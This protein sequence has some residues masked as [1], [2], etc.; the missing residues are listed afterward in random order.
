M[1]INVVPVTTLDS[2]AHSEQGRTARMSLPTYSDG[3]AQCLLPPPSHGCELAP[4]RRQG[5]ASVLAS[6]MPELALDLAFR[7]RLLA[8]HGPCTGT[9]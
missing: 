1:A 2:T 8:V 7:D 9:Q 5:F 6:L 3:Q 4:H